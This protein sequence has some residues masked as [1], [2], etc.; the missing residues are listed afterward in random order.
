MSPLLKSA[1]TTLFIGCFGVALPFM[2]GRFSKS[3]GCRCCERRR[4][5]TRARRNGELVAAH[6]ARIDLTRLQQRASSPDEAL[7]QA[8]ADRLNA[9]ALGRM[10]DGRY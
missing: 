4:A 5:A 1:V 9:M 2:L 7:A 3:P 6:D 10:T 8:R